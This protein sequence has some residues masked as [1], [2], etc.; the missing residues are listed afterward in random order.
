M[1]SELDADFCTFY[2]P[3]VTGFVALK[4][5]SCKNRQTP[6]Y[7]EFPVCLLFSQKALFVVLESGTYPLVNTESLSHQARSSHFLELSQP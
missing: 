6:N 2:L 7:T 4:S 1:P 5:R 3:R